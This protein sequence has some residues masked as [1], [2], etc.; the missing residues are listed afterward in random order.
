MQKL[1]IYRNPRLRNLMSLVVFGFLLI[2][3]V[4]SFLF[5]KYTLNT[6]EQNELTRLQGISNAVSLQINADEHQSLMQKYLY[7]DDIT[8]NAQDSIYHK[9]S[10]ILKSN[11]EA[12]ML[13]S[14]I[15][16]LLKSNNRDY[17]DFCVTS[18][19]KPYF[20]HEYKS[21]PLTLFEKYAEGGKI[22]AYEDEFGSWLSAFSPIK[23][24]NGNNVAIVMVD[25][26]LESFL[27][28]ARK[29]LLKVILLGLSIFII[30]YLAVLYMMQGILKKENEALHT[31]E[32]SNLE[33]LSIKKDLAEA[34]EKLKGVNELRKEM[35]AN[36]SHDLRT[37]LANIMG[38]LELVR[39]KPN[40]SMVQES[41]P[42]I[43]VA[44]KEAEKMNLM[45]TDL[46]ELSKLESGVINLN[47]EPFNIAELISDIAQKY[48]LNLTEKNVEVK[49]NI[50]A[51]K[52]VVFADIRY[53]DRLFQNLLD[54][55]VKFVYEGGFILLSV[56]NHNDHHLKV[57]VCNTGDP[58]SPED[59]KRIF[60]RYYKQ[61][62][63]KTGTGLGLAISRKICDLHQGEIWVEVKDNIN[64][65]IF[66]LPKYQQ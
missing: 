37:P 31:L 59:Q 15:Y 57:K 48:K 64:S 49:Y 54:N 25:E 19:H 4:L 60:D 45:V 53:V 52:L 56:M 13:N 17:Y 51:N 62:A 66:T 43:K 39:L 26:K 55:A 23:D 27:T 12:S 47:C 8:E 7:K 63:N 32:L 61:T 6:F 22:E 14:P 41:M 29:Q 18:H 46:F 44:F 9:I 35:I 34:Y 20:R 5:Y 40:D 2:I 1:S 30:M 21:F 28:T 65:F 24:K 10:K 11:Y 58:I 33:N 16:T 3:V 50:D 36:V 42:L 38:Y